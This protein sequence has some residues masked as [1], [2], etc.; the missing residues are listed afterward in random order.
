MKA[1]LEL[2]YCVVFRVLSVEVLIFSRH[3]DDIF[4]QDESESGKIVPQTSQQ[5]L[6]IG[7]TCKA[8]LN[9]DAR[10]GACVTAD[11]DQ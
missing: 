3:E 2:M 7:P 9:T 11:S 1:I 6:C 10:K 5:H 4:L 8:G